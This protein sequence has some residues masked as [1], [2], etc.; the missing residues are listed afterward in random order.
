[1]KDMGLYL[2][3]MIDWLAKKKDRPLRI[4]EC[5]TIRDPRKEG[6]ED[7]L[8]TYHIAKYVMNANAGHE[9]ISLELEHGKMVECRE[10]LKSEAL[11]KYVTFGLGDACVLMQHFNQPVDFVYLDAG[12]CPYQNLDQFRSAAKFMDAPGFVVIDDCFD[13]RNADRGRISRS[14][15]RFEMGLKTAKVVDRMCAIAFGEATEYPLPW[16]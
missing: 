7:G 1:M 13:P 15:A 6:H 10:F 16:E 11:D 8:A 2:V 4:V 14:V 12:A 9:F 3:E 5:G